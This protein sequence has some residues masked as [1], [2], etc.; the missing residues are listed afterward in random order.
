MSGNNISRDAKA[1][2]FLKEVV[3]NV[4]ADGGEKEI[5]KLQNGIDYLEETQAHLDKAGV[6]LGKAIQYIIRCPGVVSTGD[7]LVKAVAKLDSVFETLGKA[8]DDIMIHQQEEKADLEKKEE[9]E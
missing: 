6:S 7:S 9:K 5:K 2:D 4:V 8:V 3:R 1:A